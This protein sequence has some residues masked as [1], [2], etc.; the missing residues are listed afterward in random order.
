ME[1]VVLPLLLASRAFASEDERERL[2]RIRMQKG[3]FLLVMRG[4]SDWRHLY[5]F[6]PYHWGPYCSDLVADLGSLVSDGRLAD[7]S[8]FA[9]SYGTYRT[10]S[11]GEETT[12]QYDFSERQLE[13]VERVRSFVV[14]QSF[15]S[16]LTC[17]YRA[18]PTYAT[19]SVFTR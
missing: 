1:R 12:E 19:N 17:I 11:L 10:T 9:R 3:V 14:S 6:R 7:D 2:D 4:S 5:T 8:A 15:N 16:L 18:Y 13:Y